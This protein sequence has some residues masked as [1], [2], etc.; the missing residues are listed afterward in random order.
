MPITGK[1]NHLPGLP[2]WKLKLPVACI[3]VPCNGK[4][5]QKKEGFF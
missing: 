5:L 3:Y 2:H 4:K 1:N